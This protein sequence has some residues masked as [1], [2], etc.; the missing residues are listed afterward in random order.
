[1]PH[2][3]T[4]A[5]S[6]GVISQCFRRVDTVLPVK[7]LRVVVEGSVAS[8]IIDRP[9][10][11]NALTQQ[12]WAELTK[13]A[14]AVTGDP[15]IRVV[16]IRSDVAGVFSAGADIGE[17]RAHAGDVSWGVR[18]QARVEEALGAL[19]QIPVPTIAVIDGPCMGGGGGIAIACDF[20]V[21]TD[22]AVFAITAARLGLVFPFPEVAA[23]VDLVGATAA[24]RI[25][26]TGGIFDAEWARQ[27]RLVDTVC[28]AAELPVEL[29][30]WIAELGGAAPGSS[31]AMK[32]M[33]SLVVS[34]QRAATDE[35]R[36]MLLAALSGDEHREG[37]TAFLEGRPPIFVAP[38]A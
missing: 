19:R 34:G 5:V 11:R 2:E 21:A 28:A 8:V 14:R 23:L 22:R 20:R 36:E 9:A 33:I 15:R 29:A 13:I 31:R 37:V 24:K 38:S 4:A 26:L 27:A 32:R 6:L 12:M 16:V 25:L 7:E 35:T 10:K 17:Y 1:M 30:R 3:L 18:S